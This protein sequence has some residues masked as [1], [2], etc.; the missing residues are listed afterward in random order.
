M[1]VRTT[2][3][4]SLAEALVPVRTGRLDR[5]ETLVDW[6]AMERPLSHLRE[7]GPGHTLL[8]E[9]VVAKA[10][11][12]ALDDV[13]SEFLFKPLGITDYA[14][15]KNLKSGIL[16]VGGLRLRSRDL[17]KIGQLVCEWRKLEWSPDRFAGMG[18]GIHGSTYVSCGPHILL[19]IS[20]VARAFP[21]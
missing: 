21:G 7:P 13:A 10:A 5:L 14:W 4:L 2:G 18:E 6:S 16:E 1:A 12:G 8:L 3:Q 9:A 19:R 20:M 17:A 15:T 11:G